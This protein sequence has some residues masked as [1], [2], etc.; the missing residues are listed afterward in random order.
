[1]SMN[2]DEA[3]AMLRKMESRKRQLAN[4]PRSAGN[5]RSVGEFH[6]VEADALAVVLAQLKAVGLVVDQRP[7]DLCA[8][9]ADRGTFCGYCRGPS[10]GKEA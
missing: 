1:M 9:G 2:F 8:H 3:V 5:S 6:R 4:A 10:K 7:V